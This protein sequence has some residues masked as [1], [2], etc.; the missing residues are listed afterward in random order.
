MRAGVLGLLVGV[1]AL[2]LGI[3]YDAYRRP[4]ASCQAPGGAVDDASVKQG[5]YVLRVAGCAGCH[6][7]TE[8]EGAFLAGGR[9]LE[10]PFGTFYSSN[11]TP[12]PETGIGAWSLADF[13]C[14][15]RQGLAPDGAHYYP[16]FPYTAYTGM[17]DEDVRALYA[18]LRT[19]EPVRQADRP[20]ELPWYLRWRLVNWAWKRLHFQA[21]RWAPDPARPADG[22]RGQYLAEALGHCGECHTRRTPLGALER[23]WHL[24]GT[25]E[26]PEGEAVPNI[27]P[28]RATGIGTWSRDDLDYFLETGMTPEGD[29]TGGAMAE[30]LDHGLAELTREDR[31][32]LVSYLRQ[33]PP[34]EHQVGSTEKRRERDEFDY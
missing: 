29:Y 10:T 17:S 24:A 12:D 25:P 32:A 33:L 11:I 4:V 13:A 21:R 26:G 5:E 7:D 27:T 6:T 2:A 18:Y 30:V 23:E 8:G 15:L 3:Y 34:I 22:N 31:A 1:G 14:A 9:P 16:V 20:A 28:H 19:L